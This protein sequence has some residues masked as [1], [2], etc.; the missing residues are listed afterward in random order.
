MTRLAIH[1]CRVFTEPTYIR[2]RMRILKNNDH[3][4]HVSTDNNQTSPQRETRDQG[5]T[6]PKVLVLLP[7][8]NSALSWVH[9]LLNHSSASTVVHLD[10]FERE[11]SLPDGT[12]DKFSEP[13][14]EERWPEDHRRVFAGN[15][16]DTFKVGLKWTRKEVRLYSEFYSS[17]VIVASP[18]GLREVMEQER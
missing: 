2:T 12:T 9:S 3:L 8:R 18:L 1:D 5:F 14:A 7:F 10:R 16:D 17:D 6:R 4:A 11:Y 13:G 15:I